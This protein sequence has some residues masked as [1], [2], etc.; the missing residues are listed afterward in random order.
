[1]NELAPD[2]RTPKP[3]TDDTQG[4][5]DTPDLDWVAEKRKRL[6]VATQETRFKIVQNIIGH[7]HQLPTLLEL[8]Y[9]MTGVSKSTIR[10]H[11]DTLIDAGV[12]ARIELPK[13]ER[14][15]NNP[16]VFF[17]LTEVAREDLEALNLL[18]TEAIAQEA[19]LQ[20]KLTPKVEQYMHAP[21]PDWEHANP[22]DE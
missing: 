14:T 4:R 19:T 16:S 6:N 13:E 15:R 17:G 12:V 7:P 5:T 3:H 21:R 9:F 1:M 8:D 20:T 10:N 18:N 2:N 11:L 22:L